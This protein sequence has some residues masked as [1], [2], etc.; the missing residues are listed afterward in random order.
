MPIH[1]IIVLSAF[2]LLLA[3]AVVAYRWAN[4]PLISHEIVQQATFP[5][6]VPREVPDGYALEGDKT[7]LDGNMLTYT[8]AK[9][10]DGRQIVVTV[11]PVPEGFDMQ[12]LIGSGSINSISTTVG[13]LYDLS[14]GSG[15][16]Y[17][18][19]TGEVLVFLTSTVRIDTPTATTIVNSLSRQN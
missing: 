17:L 14:V 4:R 13:V 19:N 15:S 12:K 7:K 5:V 18:V 1:S 9:E 11:Q 2:A 8:F 16:K 6:Y 10:A 3:L